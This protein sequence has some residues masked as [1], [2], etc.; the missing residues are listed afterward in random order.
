MVVD[1]QGMSC[2]HCVT[3]VEK[4]LKPLK[5]VKN[6]KVEI[7]KAGFEA[8]G[9]VDKAKIKLAVEEAGFEVIGIED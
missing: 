2:K 1:I 5:G 6:L 4:A 9:N 8:H 7:G 3:A